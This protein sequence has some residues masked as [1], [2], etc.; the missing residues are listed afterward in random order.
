[1]NRQIRH[2]SF[3]PPKFCAIRY[4]KQLSNN[5]LINFTEVANHINGD[6][7]TEN[8]VCATSAFGSP[9]VIPVHW[10]AATATQIEKFNNFNFKRNSKY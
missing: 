2:Q 1:M 8:P 4:Y 7:L 9:R 6:M 5:K 3:L 10:K